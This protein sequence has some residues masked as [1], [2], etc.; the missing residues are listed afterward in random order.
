MKR[1]KA[2][3][4]RK[5]LKRGSAGEGSRKPVDLA[6]IRE[7]I[8]SLVC[9]QALGMV[10]ATI[11]EAEKGHFTATKYL[12]EMI[13]LYP[14]TD[15]EEAPGE[16]ALAKT[17]LRRLGLPEDPVLE[18]PVTKDWGPEGMADEDDTVK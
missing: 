9:H 18:N 16:N 5:N 13:G 15:Q 4:G 2:K 7:Q 3:T 12:L 17:L 14:A 8:M 10:E 11:R 1:A 6:V